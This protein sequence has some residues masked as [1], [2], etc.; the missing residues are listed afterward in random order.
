[1]SLPQWGKVA[2]AKRVTDEVCCWRSKRFSRRRKS[3]RYIVSFYIF[4]SLAVHLIHHFVVPLY[5][6]AARSPLGSNSPPDC[7][8]IPRGRFATHWGRQNEKAEG[9]CL[10]QIFS[11]EKSKTNIYTI[12][13]W[14]T[15]IGIQ[16]KQ[17]YLM[18]NIELSNERWSANDTC[19]NCIERTNCDCYSMWKMYN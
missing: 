16:S 9:D 12:E 15:S 17:I 8:S 6:A 1:M 2:R 14:T 11:K 19:S 18:Q 5:L 4:A 10:R 7:Y 3:E 13:S